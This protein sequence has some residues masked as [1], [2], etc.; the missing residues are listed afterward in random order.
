[1]SFICDYWSDLPEEVLKE[2]VFVDLRLDDDEVQS[3][4]RFP[5]CTGDEMKPE[6]ASNT[7][8]EFIQNIDPKLVLTNTGINVIG[9]MLQDYAKTKKVK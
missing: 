8:I 7:V 5:K 9:N 4:S 1:M 6:L 3:Q 2:F